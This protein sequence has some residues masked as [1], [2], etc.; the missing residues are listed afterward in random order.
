MPI[1]RARSNAEAHLY[2][3]L[4]PC[5]VCG[6][7]DVAPGST[8]TEVDG[9]LVTRFAGPCPGCGTARDFA[10]HLPAEEPFQDEEEPAFG[11]D[12]PSTLVDAGQWLWVADLIGQSLPADETGMTPEQRQRARF[13]LRIAAAAVTEAARF[14][15]GHADAVPVEALWTERG[16]SVYREDPARFRRLRLEAAHRAYRELADRLAPSAGG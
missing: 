10:F 15:P 16:R 6:E 8:I 3:E 2:M 4:N 5:A 13:D 1:L 12:E 9:R 11:D 14:L 7:L